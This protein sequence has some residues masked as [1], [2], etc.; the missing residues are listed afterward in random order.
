MK[1]PEP[2]TGTERG[3]KKGGETGLDSTL[4]ESNRGDRT[5]LPQP[6]KNPGHPHKNIQDMGIGVA[7]GIRSLGKQRK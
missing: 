3:D 7:L 1:S 2:G 6:Q 4:G 5:H